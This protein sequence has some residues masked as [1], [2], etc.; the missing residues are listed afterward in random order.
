MRWDNLFDDLEAQLEYEAD[1]ERDE[2]LAEDERLRLGRLSLRD[3]L[4][5]IAVR[6]PWRTSSSR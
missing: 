5:S 1:A 6:Q 2:L 4:S 3:R